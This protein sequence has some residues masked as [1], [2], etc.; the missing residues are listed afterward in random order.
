MTGISSSYISNGFTLRERFSSRISFLCQN[1]FLELVPF[2]EIIQEHIF[3]SYG[4]DCG[5]LK[6][7]L[8]DYGGP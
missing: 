3:M 5:F 6:E 2:C 1:D 8:Q 7:N 4:K